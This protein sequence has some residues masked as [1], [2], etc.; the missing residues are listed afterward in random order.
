MC[1]YIY[2]CMNIHMAVHSCWCHSFMNLTLNIPIGD[3][4][5]EH[6]NL[7]HF[8]QVTRRSLAPLWL[9]A[10]LSPR[11]PR[12][13]NGPLPRSR[14]TSPVARDDGPDSRCLFLGKI[15]WL[16]IMGILWEYYGNTMV[17]WRFSRFVRIIHND[18]LVGGWP[19]PPNKYEFVKWDDDSWCMER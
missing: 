5:F 8:C 7:G 6:P 2:T 9:S 4:P 1:K 12:G 14:G 11:R 15:C 18:Y 16:D 17:L 13:R 3:F 19:T 10:P